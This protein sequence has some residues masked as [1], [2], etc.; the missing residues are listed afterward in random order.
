MLTK[1]YNKVT[2]SD[3][4]SFAFFNMILGRDSDILKNVE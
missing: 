4:S 1:T 2:G 3:T